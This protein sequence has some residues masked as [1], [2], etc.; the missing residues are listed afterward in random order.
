MR[1]ADEELD[2]HRK[3]VEEAIPIL[4]EFLYRSYSSGWRRVWVVHGKGS[5]V[6]RREVTRYL[7]RHSLVESFCPA[8]RYH[9]GIGATEVRLR[10][11]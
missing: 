3:T 6:L 11:S 9:G 8:D 10:D 5:G 7:G 4:D 1:Q 2:L